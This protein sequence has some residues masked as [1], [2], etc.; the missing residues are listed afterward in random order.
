ME[1]VGFEAL[2]VLFVL[3]PGFLSAR[4]V[5]SLCV[6]ASQSELEKFVEALLYSF[7][8][9]VVFVAAFRRVPLAVIEKVS[10]DGSRVYRPDLGSLDLVVL[11][12]IAGVLGTFISISITNDLHGKFF[13][14]IRATQRTTR[15]SIW[16]DVFHDL[17]F[18]VQ[19]QFSD[20]RKLIGWPRYFSDTPEEAS[21]FL[22]KAAWIDHEGKEEDIPG[23]GI[24]ITKNMPIETIMFLKGQQTK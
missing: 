19:V 23:P 16:N 21:L 22:E 20:G 10:P 5:Q 6:R 18:F 13:R 11:L 3:L 7:V 8:T 4:V 24:L 9:Y 15:P 1:G 2:A 14:F 17:S 12:L